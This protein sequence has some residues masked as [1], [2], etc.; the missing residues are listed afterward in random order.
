MTW[1][2]RCGDDAV[3]PRA[4]Q[5]RDF[6]WRGL[7]GNTP[8]ER[9]A[10]I[11]WLNAIV[12]RMQSALSL[13]MSTWYGKVG[14][15]VIFLATV[16]IIALL[17][18][19]PRSEYP[20]IDAEKSVDYDQEISIPKVS[21]G[22]KSMGP[23]RENAADL[24]SQLG[25]DSRWTAINVNDP[26][27]LL[28]DLTGI[29]LWKKTERNARF[30][31]IP[32]AHTMDENRHLLIRYSLANDSFD[33]GKGMAEKISLVVYYEGGGQQ[34]YYPWRY[35]GANEWVPVK[36]NTM[37]SREM[38]FICAVQLTAGSPM[39][40]R[41]DE[42]RIF[43][44]WHVEKNARGQIAAGPIVISETQVTW[45]TTDSQPCVSNYQLTSIIETCV[46]E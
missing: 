46:S 15:G 44:T 16:S 39:S 42:A 11:S 5:T 41:I 33:C 40:A 19:I 1:G 3:H 30:Q 36:P 18:P 37:L 2:R 6:I 14:L 9:G 22:A 38:E 45:T 4:A 32:K 31:Y 28:I 7:V 25:V 23:L 12:D 34:T 21:G 8:R 10:L 24:G 35:P 13:A 27:Q 17:N 29:H 26:G 43:G 20:K